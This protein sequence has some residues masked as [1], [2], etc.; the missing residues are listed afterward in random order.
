MTVPQAVFSGV[1]QGITEFLPI[2][3]SAHLVFLHHFLRLNEPQLLFDVLLHGGTLLAVLIY[4]RKK[5]I[6]AFTARKNLGL[7]VIAGTLPLLP[8]GAAFSFWFEDR[9]SDLFVNARFAAAMLMITGA[10]LLLSGI[11][12]A[13]APLESGSQ[14]RRFGCALLVGIAQAVALLP[15]ISRSGSTIATALLLGVNGED[16][17]E[18]SFLLAVPATILALGVSGLKIVRA[19]AAAGDGSGAAF[20]AGMVTAAVVGLLTVRLLVFAVN[21]RKFHFFGFYCLAAGSAVL[22]TG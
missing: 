11:K 1:L 21:R 12:K 22:M 19:G 13:G 16:A 9:F 4:F 5:I 8:V 15:G 18:F 2:S 3:S 14:G 6:A 20:L 17:V 7:L 10:W